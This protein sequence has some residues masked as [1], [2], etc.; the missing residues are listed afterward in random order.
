MVTP[1]AAYARVQVRWNSASKDWHDVEYLHPD[2]VGAQ[3]ASYGWTKY[4]VKVAT[5]VDGSGAP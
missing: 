5:Q 3:N 2:E 4:R 1:N